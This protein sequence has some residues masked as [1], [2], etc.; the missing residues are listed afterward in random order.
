MNREIK[1]R[2]KRI[3]NDEWVYGSLL[4]WP[5]GDCTI[6]E[7]K[8]DGSNYVWKREIDP[9]TVGQFTG[10]HDADG[11]EIYEGDIIESYGGGKSRHVISYDERHASFVATLVDE[12]MGTDLETR[13]PV[14]QDWIYKFDKRVIG[15]IFDNPEMLK[16]E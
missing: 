12:R 9:K 8:D 11:K 13:C 6:L 14:T 2:G 4:R 3:A 10:L 15:N 16:G 5:D 1:F 7:S